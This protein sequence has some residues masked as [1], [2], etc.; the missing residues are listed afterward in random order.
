MG[1]SS[2]VGL[3][4][5]C[6]QSYIYDISAGACKGLIRKYK[7]RKFLREAEKKIREFCLRNESLYIDSDAFRNF[8]DY[9]KPFDK[10]MQNAISM[11]DSVD[12]NQLSNSIVAEAEEA[13]KTS[14]VILSVDDRRIVKDL[15][16]LVSNEITRYFQDVLDDGQK[17]TVS[18]NAQSTNLIRKDIK[19]VVDGN[20]KN[21]AS[22]EK[23]MRE[24][25]SISA[26]KAEPIAELICKK[27]WLGEFDEV[28]SICQLVAS[29]SN[30]LEL[31]IHVLNM[32]MLES[33]RDNNDL[34]NSIAHI[35][36]I[37]IR[38]TVIRNIIPL[39]YFRKEKF[40]ELVSYTDSE[41]LKAIMSALNN[42]DYSYLFSMETKLENG[43][44]L[45]KYT[46]NKKVMEMESWLVSQVFGIYMYNM[47]PV[48]AASL[49]E[50]TIDAQTSWFSA[51]ITYDKKTDMLVY[52]GP[53]TKT[54]TEMAELEEM[55]EHKKAIYDKLADDLSAVYY[56]LI[57]KLSLVCGKNG[58][59]IVK[60][61][62]SKLQAIRPVKDF[63]LATRVESGDIGFDELYK[64]CEDVGEY[65]LLT[66]YIINLRSNTEDLIGLIEEHENLLDKSE[67]IFFVYVETLAHLDNRRAEVKIKLDE[68]KSI[69][70]KYFEFWNVYLNIDSSV[71]EEFIGLCK[72]N[73]IVYL[74]GH[75]GCILV[76]RLISFEEYDLAEFYNN[77][78]EVQHTNYTQSKIF[79]AF[80]LNG[81]GKQIDALECFKE[82]YK[83]YPDDLSIIN[84]ILS[85]SINLKRRIEKEYIRNAEESNN[86]K[87]L[88][89]AGSAYATNGDFA[90]ARRCNMKAMFMSDDCGNLA[91]NQYLG[92]NLQ[93]RHEEIQ[94]ISSVE[95]NTV[96]HLENGIQ[97]QTYCIHGDRELPESPYTWHGD[98]HLYIS[99][100]A[101]L[102]IYRRHVGDEIEIGESKFTIKAIEPIEAYIT[103]ICF[104]NIVKNG[105]AKAIT[106]TEINGHIDTESLINQMKELMPD[107]SERIDWI[108]QYNNFE[109][110]ALPLHM[111]KKQYNATYTQFVEL[112]I[113]EPKSCIR[114]AIN[115]NMPGNK[116]FILSFTAMIIL[117]MIGISNEFLSEHN[118]YVTESTVIQ[119]E[120]D[121]SEMI[122]YYAN[123]SVTSMGFYEGKPYRIDTD[124][125]T[126]D[127]WIK[128]SGELRNFVEGIPSVVCK[129]D[130]K[131]SMFDQLN[132]TEILGTPDYDAISIGIN[133]N[134]TVIGMEAMITALA[135][136]NEINAEVVSVTNW[137]ISTNID[138][139]S[140]IDIV[141]KLVEKGCIYSLTE[142]MVAYILTSLERAQDEE[143]QKILFAW[144]SLLE[145]YGSLDKTYKAY[146]I[147][148]LRNVYVSAYEKVDKQSL[149]PI[150]RIFSQRLMWLFKLK[151]TTR[152]NENGELEIMY[153]Q[154]QDDKIQE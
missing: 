16:T 32:E 147:E 83:D 118:V 8:I 112:L 149:N 7:Q 119:I 58:G 127:K 59:E 70:G 94:E 26:Y 102:G 10:V 90:A 20:N 64:F 139:I 4:L 125:D 53:N 77:Q 100:A 129:K 28:E 116:K 86:A 133:D 25:N 136:N 40:D 60:N 97:E 98:T 126:K 144:D 39:L 56:A 78:L 81:K 23:L 51:L 151:V 37:R 52:E 148:S 42:D 6:V 111:M 29:K 41:Y 18:Q 30:D 76:E 80:I 31:A 110:V 11:S 104:E 134:Y 54:K 153:Y 82:V 150:M 49:I 154:L 101:K 1:E 65:W 106:T 137:L 141:K 117:K 34:K 72:D 44:E 99:D 75:V 13:A 12:I 89:L 114:E 24:A 121:T 138:V 47:R 91:F 50:S 68:Y 67:T 143:I 79:K 93:D 69:Y 132:M 38:N 131:N 66:N 5:S 128:E 71:K 152:I 19:N 142:Q 43:I 27:M 122:A 61:I 21:M 36:N 103:R 92:L 35:D 74:S 120:R 17:Y 14:N 123:D 109:D 45:R 85:I 2:I 108:Q 33:N 105:S 63:M 96:V 62:P 88:V 107:S 145:A 57:I 113:E 48:N 46:L 135:M 9:H 140:L 146:G 73:K 22:L 124:E 115:N 130:W 84:A 3:I 15:M 87:L 55:L 95:K